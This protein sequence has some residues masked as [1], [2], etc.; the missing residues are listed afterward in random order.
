MGAPPPDPA[1]RGGR[2]QN[3]SRSTYSGPEKR[4]AERSTLARRTQ[5][6]P[7]APLLQNFISV[8]S[9]LSVSLRRGSFS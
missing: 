5:A 2:N 6:E 4:C 3:A 1:P 8:S 7:L 9:D